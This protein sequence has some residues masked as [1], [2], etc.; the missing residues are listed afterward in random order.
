MRYSVFRFVP[1][2]LLLLFVVSCSKSPEAEPGAKAR[3]AMSLA[4]LSG[5]LFVVMKS[6]D[7]KRGAGVE[8]F[9]IE[10]TEPFESAWAKL[11]SEFKADWDV[12]FAAYRQAKERY[13]RTKG[14]I[15]TEKWMPAMDEWRRTSTHLDEVRDKYT[16]RAVSLIQSTSHKSARTDV[17]GHYELADI[18]LGKHYIFSHHKVFNN[19]IYWMIPADL[20]GGQNKVDLSNSNASWPFRP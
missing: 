16:A 19:E 14:M 15:G 18:K 4:S 12:A 17:N 5:D 3:G 6:G 9:L 13:D 7:V 8:T 2:F 11:L 20:K 1:V 10:S